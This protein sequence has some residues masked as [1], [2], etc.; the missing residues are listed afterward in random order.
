[1]EQDRERPQSPRAPRET[2]Q[3]HDELQGRG[4]S[5]RASWRRRQHQARPGDVRGWNKRAEPLQ[6]EETAQEKA[7]ATPEIARGLQMCHVTRDGPRLPAP[8]YRPS[9]PRSL[10]L[11]ASK[12]PQAALASFLPDPEHPLALYGTHPSGVPGVLPD[13]RTFLPVKLG[14]HFFSPRLRGQIPGVR[15]LA[16]QQPA[17]RNS[18]KSE[19]KKGDQ[20]SSFL[21]TASNTREASV[22]GIQKTW[23]VC[24]WA[25]FQASGLSAGLGNPGPVLCNRCLS[26]P[27]PWPPPTAAQFNGRHIPAAS[28]AVSAAR[29]ALAEAQEG[30]APRPGTTTEGGGDGPRPRGLIGCVSSGKLLALSES[31]RFLPLSNGDE[32]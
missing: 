7:A 20:V 17:A 3:A 16:G 2:G 4:E 11:P 6:T 18:R 27:E 24:M 12:A 32:E 14:H 9:R 22:I 28:P 13:P 31:Q 10:P 15:F 25:Q 5:G 23:N 26:R 30:T 21:G 8:M 1:M 29:T 19:D